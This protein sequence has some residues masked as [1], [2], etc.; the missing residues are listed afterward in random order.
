M[1]DNEIDVNEYWQTCDQCQK[2]GNM[3]T[4]NLT[5]L[6]TILPTEPF[7]KWGLDFIE[8]VKHASQ[9]SSN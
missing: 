1:V 8:H 4:Q 7:Q 6:V 5:K 9:M 2:T 3:L